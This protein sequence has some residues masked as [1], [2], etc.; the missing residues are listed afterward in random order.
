MGSTLTAFSHPVH[1]QILLVLLPRQNWSLATAHYTWIS[2]KVLPLAWK[3]PHFLSNLIFHCSPIP[4]SRCH[5][6]MCLNPWGTFP[7][8]ASAPAAPSAWMLISKTF[9]PIYHQLCLSSNPIFSMLLPSTT[10]I[11]NQ[12]F[13]VYLISSPFYGTYHFLTNY[14]HVWFFTRMLSSS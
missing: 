10:L 8:R 2:A 4:C 9:R 5:G 1:K 7:P 14:I 6:H 3:L 11:I 13:P 12:T